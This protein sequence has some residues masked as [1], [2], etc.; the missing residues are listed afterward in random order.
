LILKLNLQKN[1]FCQ[2]IFYRQNYPDKILL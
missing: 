2:K 1:I